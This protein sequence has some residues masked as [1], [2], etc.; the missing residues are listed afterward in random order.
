MTNKHFEWAVKWLAREHNAG[1][2]ITVATDF[3]TALFRSFGPNFDPQ[4]FDTK[5][6]E[7]TKREV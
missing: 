3:A 2:D 5:L 1:V 6:W 7:L 4:R